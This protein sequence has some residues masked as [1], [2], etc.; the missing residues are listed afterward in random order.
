MFSAGGRKLRAGRPRSPK[1]TE[2]FRLNPCPSVVELKVGR[3]CCSAGGGA[4][5]PY[6][7]NHPP[8]VGAEVTRREPEPETNPG[9]AGL[10]LR[11]GK[12]ERQLGPTSSSAPKLL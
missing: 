4:P 12:A 2:S 9:R 1:A 7:Q 5:P 6:P 8:P 10:P 3:S 11:L